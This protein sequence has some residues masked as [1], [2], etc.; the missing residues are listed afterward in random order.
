LDGDLGAGFRAAS[1]VT[2]VG[3]KHGGVNGKE[4]SIG[5]GLMGGIGCIMSVT[6]QLLVVYDCKWNLVQ[7]AVGEDSGTNGGFC[8]IVICQ[9]F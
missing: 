7:K 5:G 2:A 4:F 9:F 8:M 3:G 6:H 1:Y